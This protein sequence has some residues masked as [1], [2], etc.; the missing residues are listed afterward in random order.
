MR[1]ACSS[2]VQSGL[3]ILKRR[4][5]AGLTSATGQKC[6]RRSEVRDAR[7]SVKKVKCDGGAVGQR[8]EM[9]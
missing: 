6:E 5:I 8:G 1:V 3:Q 9:I 7:D 2:Y 4:T